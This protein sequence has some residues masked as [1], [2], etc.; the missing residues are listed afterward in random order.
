MIARTPASR[1]A[2]VKMDTAYF[3]SDPEIMLPKVKY[4]GAAGFAKNFS[5]AAETFPSASGWYVSN[6]PHTW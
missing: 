4:T 5:S 6:D 3:S 2:W 1:A